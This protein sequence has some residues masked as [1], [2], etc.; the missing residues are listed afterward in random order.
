MGVITYASDAFNIFDAV[1]VI[2][3]MFELLMKVIDDSNDGGGAVTVLR[4]GRLFRIF[5]LARA[6]EALQQVILTVTKSF[7]KILPLSIILLLFM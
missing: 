7:S 6:W 2:T 3:S 5:K 1:I 4:A